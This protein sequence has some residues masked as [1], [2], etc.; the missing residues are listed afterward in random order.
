MVRAV[1]EGLAVDRRAGGRER[2]E[3]GGRLASGSKASRSSAGCEHVHNRGWA[4]E[5]REDDICWQERSGS[6]FEVGAACEHVLE[7]GWAS[8]LLPDY[9]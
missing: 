8:L 2:D 9:V 1:I 3:G 5:S 6:L 7:P 4:S